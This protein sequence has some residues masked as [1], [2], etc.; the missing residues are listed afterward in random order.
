M[1]NLPT[2]IAFEL[3]SICPLH[4]NYC[5]MQN[6]NKYGVER[7]KKYMKF[8]LFKNIIDEMIHFEKMPS[9]ILSY[10]GESLVHPKFIQFLEYLDKYSMR[11]WITTSLLGGSIE[12]LNA[13]IDYCDTISVSLDGNKEMFTKNRGSVK[14]FEKVNEQLELLLDE[15]NRSDV[16]IN[17]NMTLSPLYD[18]NSISVRNFIEHW[19]SSVD[20]I[21]IW[22]QIDFGEN[23]VYLYRD[24]LEEHLKRRRPC[25]QPFNYAAI[26]TDGR[27]APCCNTSRTVLRELNIADGIVD[28]FTSNI[29]Q[30]FLDNHKTLHIKGSPC[31]SC[32]LW[33]DDWLGDEKS[34]ITIN[35]GDK[36]TYYHEGNTIRFPSVAI[37]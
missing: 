3:V 30:E 24:G 37:S 10:E 14:Q 16:K 18:I 15:K 6:W 21:Y 1:N 8:E 31:E 7:Q 35:T 28:T 9:I 19:M 4:C 29:Y 20:E 11:P 25:Q 32:E 17:L 12:K 27:I 36:I 26:L 2:T 5:D 34:S 33:L 13:M 22:K 23:I